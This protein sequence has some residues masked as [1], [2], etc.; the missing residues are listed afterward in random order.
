MKKEIII[1][2]KNGK[3]GRVASKIA[4][5][6]RGKTDADFLPNKVEFP[7]VFVKNVDEM[8]LSENKLKKTFFV[9]YSGYPGGLKETSAFLIAQKDKREL[10]K[11]AVWGMIKNTRLK[12]RMLK[13]LV[14]FHGDKE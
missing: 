2:A 12:K 8:D 7:K 14:L 4:V 1:D 11:L 5:S 10:L 3:L 13:N 9:R 6:L